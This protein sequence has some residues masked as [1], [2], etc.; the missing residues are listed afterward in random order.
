VA[1]EHNREFI[2]DWLNAIRDNPLLVDPIKKFILEELQNFAKE[3]LSSVAGIS[4]LKDIVDLAQV[5]DNINELGKLE[6][7]IS[8]LVY[9]LAAGEMKLS[10]TIGP[11]TKGVIL[12]SFKEL[13]KRIWRD[14]KLEDKSL[15]GIIDFYVK[16]LV[17]TEQIK[18]G[19]IEFVS[20]DD[21]S[22]KLRFRNDPFAV[23]IRHVIDKLG[24]VDLGNIC[25]R[26]LSVVAFV[27]T[28]TEEILDLKVE[29]FSDDECVISLNFF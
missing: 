11:I 8:G 3:K 24:N 7:V 25:L 19:D 16:Y 27:R 6:L 1:I 4:E 13:N 21:S 15:K 29:S 14:L 17:E 23:A 10:G 20:V 9:S 28:V 12:T 22:A 18:D 26:G 5:V 2:K